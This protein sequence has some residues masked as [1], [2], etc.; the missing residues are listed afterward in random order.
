[1]NEIIEQARK[2]GDNEGIKGLA[3]HARVG[4]MCGC[5][6]CFCCAAAQVLGEME[7]HARRLRLAISRAEA[8]RFRF[9]RAGF[10]EE[11]AA[12]TVAVKNTR[13]LLTSVLVGVKGA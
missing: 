5:G 1:M 2:L 8:D 10:P 13:G 7:E 3:P 9:E 4:R 12:L 6:S 11:A